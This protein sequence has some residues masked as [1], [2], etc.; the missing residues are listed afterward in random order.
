MQNKA[1]NAAA[2]YASYAG[3]TPGQQRGLNATS[4]PKYGFYGQYQVNS[5]F[6]SKHFGQHSRLGMSPAVSKIM[7]LRYF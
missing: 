3:L 6:F 7:T 1:E 4:L 5:L 2:S